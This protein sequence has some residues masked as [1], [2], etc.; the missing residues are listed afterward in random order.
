M[1]A[2]FD[3]RVAVLGITVAALM[4][5]EWIA[6]HLEVSEE[7][8]LVLI[9]GL[10]EG[11]TR[12]IAEKFGVR[13]EKGPKQLHEIPAHFGREM[14]SDYGG[15]DIEIAA[16]INNAPR[17]GADDVL[18]AAETFVASGADIVDIG[19]TPGLEFPMLGSIVREIRGAGIRV[20][21]DSFVES[22]IRIAVEAGAELV[23][24]VN[25]S[26]IDVAADLSGSGARVVAVPDLGG[27]L[28]SVD[29][30]I[31]KLAGWGVPYLID[32]ILEPLVLVFLASL[33][34]YSDGRRR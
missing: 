14:H 19:C 29:P 34:G 9:P 11:D 16:E 6:R 27:D 25:S 1:D 23:L 8:D 10:C 28:D 20:S 13:V 22:E 18:R 5:T 31:E 17:L 24:S 7:I 15:W 4:T 21:I 32:P 33:V 26:N 3:C 2:P 12:P 30:T